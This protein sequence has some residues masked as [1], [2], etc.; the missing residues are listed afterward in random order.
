MDEI[1]VVIGY[2]HV[3]T[4]NL[5]NQVKQQRPWL[6][7]QWVTVLDFQFS[8]NGWEKIIEVCHER[9]GLWLDGLW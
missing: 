2:W 7:L 8:I 4:V 1:S 6:V 5:Y 3:A 9:G